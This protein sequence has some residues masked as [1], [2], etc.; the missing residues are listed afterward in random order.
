MEHPEK[1]PAKHQAY[2]KRLQNELQKEKLR[3]GFISYI[4]PTDALYLDSGTAIH[5]VK[6]EYLFVDIKSYY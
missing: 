2:Y 1:A 6:D 5:V 4:Q 3:I